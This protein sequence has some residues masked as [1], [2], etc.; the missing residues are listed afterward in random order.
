MFVCHIKN[1]NT[2]T[3]DH[4]PFENQQSFGTAVISEEGLLHQFPFQFSS[5]MYPCGKV[6]YSNFQVW[7][8]DK[9][10][11]PIKWEAM[12]SSLEIKTLQ[13]IHIILELI[14]L[15]GS[16]C[17]FIAFKANSQLALCFLP[18]RWE[19]KVFSLDVV[20]IHKAQVHFFGTSFGVAELWGSSPLAVSLSAVPFVSSMDD[21]DFWLATISA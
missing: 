15:K 6:I 13:T 18:L 2:Q 12:Y 1:N 16:S 20:T 14:F 7:I 4:F 9:C 19:F 17:R 8:L 21:D 5:K 10:F 3:N 11:F